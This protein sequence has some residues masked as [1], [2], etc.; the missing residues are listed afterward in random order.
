MKVHGKDK[1]THIEHYFDEKNT[2]HQIPIV[3]LYGDY[4]NT[5]TITV[6]YENGA[7]DEKM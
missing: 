6:S 1:Y 4:E 3:G 2:F 7:K 5:M